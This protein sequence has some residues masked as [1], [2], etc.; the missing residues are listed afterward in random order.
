MLENGIVSLRWQSAS[1]NDRT[2]LDVTHGPRLSAAQISGSHGF[3]LRIVVARCCSPYVCA[4][5]GGYGAGRCAC[6]RSEGG[7]SPNAMRPCLE[8][9]NSPH[10]SNNGSLM[11]PRSVHS[12]IKTR[13]DPL[14]APLDRCL[15]SLSP[16]PTA[17]NRRANPRTSFVSSTPLTPFTISNV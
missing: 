8:I 4:T 5:N 14:L 13:L 3:W 16:P 2:L 11:F 17:S 9:R 1:G 7:T 6:S 15:F 10:L 12:L